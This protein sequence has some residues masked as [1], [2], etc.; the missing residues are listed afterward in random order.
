MKRVGLKVVL[1]SG[2]LLIPAVAAGVP[3]ARRPRDAGVAEAGVADA[4]AL[5]VLD[6]GAAVSDAAVS[7]AGVADAD[8]TDASAATDDAGVG[9]AA[10]GAAAAGTCVEHVPP[11][12]KRPAVVE[13]LPPRGVS[14]YATELHLVITHGKGETVLPDGFRLQASSDAA[15]ALEKAGFVIPDPGGGAVPK[16]SVAPGAAGTAVTTITIPVVPLPPK[17]GRNTLELP[18]LPIAIARANNEFVTVCTAP[19]AIVIE[20]PIANELDPKVKPNPPGRAQREDWP[21]A[22]TL[23]I[24]V[25]GGVALVVIGALLQRWWKKRPRIVP[26]PPRIPPWTT[27]L[28]EL[29]EIRRS[30]LLEDGKLGEHFDR[31]SFALRRYLGARY[32]FEAVGQG[33]GG[34]ETTTGEMLDLLNRVRP[35]IPELP[36]IKDFLDDCDLV[37]FARFTPTEELCRQ[38]LDRGETIVRRTIPVMQLPSAPLSTG[39]P[40]LSTGEAPTPTHPPEGSS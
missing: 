15:K 7:D 19:H 8:T 20:D 18:P 32:G 11:G 16:I 2:V 14:G 25:P 4:G 26:A 1:M 29:D 39:T 24:A 9:T 28:A 5:A 31:V 36:R 33:E 27:A 21:L 38:A 17:A 23:A 6:A 37:K 34:L 22:R 12:A 3:R 10:S 13:G 30:D 35:P 40:P